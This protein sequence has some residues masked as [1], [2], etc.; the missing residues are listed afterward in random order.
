MYKFHDLY[1][2]LPGGGDSHVK[3]AGMLVVS[4][5]GV[6]Y[7]FWFHFGCSGQNANISLTIRV[8]FRVAREERVD[9]QN[10]VIRVGALHPA[11]HAW[12]LVFFMGQIKSL[13]RVQIGLLYGFNSNYPMP[14]FYATFALESHREPPNNGVI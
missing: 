8:S 6:N 7:G 3:G 9:H 1:S 10:V 5:R 14:S 13:S 12:N 4:F 11:E 2:L